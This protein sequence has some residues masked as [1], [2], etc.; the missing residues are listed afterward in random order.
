MA[1]LQIEIRKSDARNVVG[2]LV[3]AH[4]RRMDPFW[5]KRYLR[6]LKSSRSPYS[7]LLGN[8]RPVYLEAR[9]RILMDVHG[10]MEGSWRFRTW[11]KRS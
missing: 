8:V 10:Y 5:S 11:M 4:A 2:R 9:R 3:L 6:P 7:L 1:V